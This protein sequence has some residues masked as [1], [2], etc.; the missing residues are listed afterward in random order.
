[1]KTFWKRWI[2]LNRLHRFIKIKGGIKWVSEISFLNWIMNIG[3]NNIVDDEGNFIPTD[4]PLKLR[5][6]PIF[7]LCFNANNYTESFTEIRNILKDLAD[8]DISWIKR[9]NE[10]NL[11]LSIRGQDIYAVSSLIFLSDY[12]RRL[13]TGIIIV[14]VT[15]WII[16]SIENIKPQVTQIKC[17]QQGQVSTT[18]Q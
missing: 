11:N 12:G 7:Y 14:L 17:E 16:Y 3:G 6:C 9:N 4:Y 10:N 8:P 15:W 13:W 18:P 1:M 5:M 2:I